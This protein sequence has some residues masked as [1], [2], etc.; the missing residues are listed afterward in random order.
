MVDTMEEQDKVEEELFQKQLEKKK[1][2]ATRTFE[3]VR[4]EFT[5]WYSNNISPDLNWSDPSV[6]LIFN[7][8]TASQAGRVWIT[9]KD[10][11]KLAAYAKSAETRRRNEERRKAMG[12]YQ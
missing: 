5:H 7:S 4:D 10:E 6:H 2:Q 9:A 8:W 12:V 11:R 3:I 1:M